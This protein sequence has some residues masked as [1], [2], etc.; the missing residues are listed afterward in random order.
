ML[1][2]LIGFLRTLTTPER[3]IELL[4]TVLTGWLGY[5]LLFGVVFAETGL[6]ARQN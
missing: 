5:A 4:T 2:A 6:R 3:L 1:Q